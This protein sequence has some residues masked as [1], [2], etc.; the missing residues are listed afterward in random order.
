M[1]AIVLHSLFEE[2]I[3]HAEVDLQQQLDKGADSFS[4]AQSYFPD[5]G[6]Y[7]SGPDGYLAL[8][9]RIKKKVDTPLIASLNG[10]TPGGWSRYARKLYDAGADALELNIYHLVT[11]PSQDSAAVEQLYLDALNAVRREVTLR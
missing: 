7:D 5:L 10:V 9:D 11:D 8:I 4:E 3:R 2:E 6:Y 1:G